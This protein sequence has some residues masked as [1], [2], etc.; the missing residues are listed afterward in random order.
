MQ[1]CEVMTIIDLT[2]AQ[3]DSCE[4]VAR[5]TALDNCKGKAIFFQGRYPAHSGNVEYTVAW[6]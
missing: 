5:K 6:L 1:G 2:E 4:Q 3:Q